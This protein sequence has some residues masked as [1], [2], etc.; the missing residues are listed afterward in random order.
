MLWS[1]MQSPSLNAHIGLIEALKCLSTVSKVSGVSEKANPKT[2]Y[3]EMS[4][5][6][7]ILL[8]IDIK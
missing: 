2:T 4:Q 3:S 5:S 6:V 1:T 8:E 7:K